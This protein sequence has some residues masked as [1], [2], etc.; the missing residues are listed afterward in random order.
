VLG[1][2]QTHSTREP[3]TTPLRFVT[4]ETKHPGVHHSMNLTDFNQTDRALE[5]L[6]DFGE[7]TESSIGCQQL[8]LVLLAQLVE[9]L[10]GIQRA[11]INL[12]K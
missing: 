10:Q 7:L 9:V 4:S 3:Q 2:A 6:I 11:I 8:Q 1:V 5:K 12:R